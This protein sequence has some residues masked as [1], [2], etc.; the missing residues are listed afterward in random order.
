MELMSA[1]YRRPE[2]PMISRASTKSVS[3]SKS[4][5]PA[6]AASLEKA[7]AEDGRKLNALA[8]AT[9]TTT[10]GTPPRP[11]K[12]RKK[13]IPPHLRN[14][15]ND[16]GK[17]CPSISFTQCSELKLNPNAKMYETLVKREDVIN[18]E[19]LAW[20]MAS[21]DP[22]TEHAKHVGISNTMLPILTNIS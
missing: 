20:E 21:A 1:P 10:L 8:A 22:S 17:V 3:P 19:A 6:W 4:L 11:E 14:K 13:S 18:D 7:L 15:I 16:E 5:P 12:V 2:T 9:T